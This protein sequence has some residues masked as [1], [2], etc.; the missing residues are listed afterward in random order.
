MGNRGQQIPPRATGVIAGTQPK[1]FRKDHKSRASGSFAVSLKRLRVRL[2]PPPGVD[3][4]PAA[5]R[6]ERR[7]RAA[8]GK[9]CHGRQVCCVYCDE[10]MLASSLLAIGSF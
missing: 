1:R 6:T 4:L 10:T 2:H 7:S 3:E 9:T 8:N 5:L